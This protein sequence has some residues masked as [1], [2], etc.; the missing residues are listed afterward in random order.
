L[1]KAQGRG[2]AV[3]HAHFLIAR[4]EFHADRDFLRGFDRALWNKARRL[5]LQPSQIIL[6]GHGDAARF[7]FELVR[8]VNWPGLAPFWSI[9][10]PLLSRRKS[11]RWGLPCAFCCMAPPTPRMIAPLT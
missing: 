10:L 3:P 5:G 4:S 1:R 6:V 7:A 11:L 2:D 9:C 8:T